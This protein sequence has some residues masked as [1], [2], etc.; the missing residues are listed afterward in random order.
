MKTMEQL[1]DLSET[2]SVRDLA[3]MLLLKSNRSNTN[4]EVD[5]KTLIKT[6][7]NLVQDFQNFQEVVKNESNGFIVRKAFPYEDVVNNIGGIIELVQ[8]PGIK[9]RY[10]Q[11][12]F[13]GVELLANAGFLRIDGEEMDFYAQTLTATTELDE[14]ISSM[15]IKSANEWDFDK[16][17]K[18]LIDLVIKKLF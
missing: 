10:L 1:S 9:R 12:D 17:N 11:I 13:Y 18:D 2:L 7:R 4:S 5:K 6:N 14:F 3:T 15:R 8:N 16:V